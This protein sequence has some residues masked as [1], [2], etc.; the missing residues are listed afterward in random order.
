MNQKKQ[1]TVLAAAAL[2]FIIAAFISRPTNNDISDAGTKV[3]PDLFAH[4]NDVT[5]IKIQTS[6]AKLTLTKDKD[7]WK[8][9]ENNGYP[10]NMSNI[11]SLVLGLSNLKRI[12]PKTSTPE[13]YSRIGLQDV[14][15]KGSTSTHIT[16][17]AGQDKKLADVIIGNSKQSK[18]DPTQKSY[19]IR[20]IDDPQSW[21]VDGSLPNGWNPK[22]WL[23]TEIVNIKRERIKQVKVTHSDGTEVYIHRDSPDTRDFTLEGLKP[24]EEVNAPYEV[25]NIATTFTKMTFDNVMKDT[26]ASLPDKPDYTAVL[27]TFDGLEVTF[28]PHKKDNK[29]WVTY[30]ARYDDTIAKAFQTQQKE[31]EST[32]KPEPAPDAANTAKES[33]KQPAPKYNLETPEQVKQEAEKYNARWKNWAYELPEF[34]VANIGK[35]KTDLLKK[36]DKP[37]LKDIHQS[38]K[39]SKR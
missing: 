2:I 6:S 13:N 4:A 25:N 1:L 21:L 34:R 28:Q 14:S 10:A 9:E 17:F 29:H 15:E 5:N 3:F 24:G 8:V 27:T 39:A 30:S 31:Q 37:V 16:V 36:H 23:D 7:E 12:E 22:E 32:S 20:T 38:K 19:Y 18:A 26:D 35:T 33:T 11:R